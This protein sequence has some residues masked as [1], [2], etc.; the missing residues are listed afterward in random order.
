MHH[1]TLT[2]SSTSRTSPSIFS[3]K[4]AVSTFVKEW[5]GLLEA[6]LHLLGDVILAIV[7][8]IIIVNRWF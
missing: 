4:G 2:S 8:S 3:G 5:V 1:D 7:T 6:F